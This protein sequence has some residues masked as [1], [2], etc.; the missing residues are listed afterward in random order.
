MTFFQTLHF[1]L[2]ILHWKW[3]DHNLVTC[4]QLQRWHVAV[5][6][7]E[8]NNN[9]QLSVFLSVSYFDDTT[10]VTGISITILTSSSVCTAF[11][12]YQLV[13]FLFT[14]LTPPPPLP[15][16]SSLSPV[17]TSHRAWQHQA[18]LHFNL[19]LKLLISLS[20]IRNAES[21]FILLRGP[22]PCNTV[23]VGPRVTHSLYKVTLP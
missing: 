19:A 21:M 16:S 14:S 5:I 18:S 22:Y 17:A 4:M 12:G 10:S 1:E 13:I 9:R 15:P 2:N 20:I 6:W 11:F 23:I 7:A 3:I 8:L